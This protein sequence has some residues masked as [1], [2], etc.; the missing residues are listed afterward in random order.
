MITLNMQVDYTGGIHIS[1]LQKIEELKFKIEDK[2]CVKISFVQ[3]GN[4]SDPAN[5]NAIFLLGREYGY[6]FKINIEGQE[7]HM[8]KAKRVFLRCARGR[9]KML[10]TIVA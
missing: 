10:E 5:A 9:L 7:N 8:E 1:P 4:E 2:Y 6:Q 3:I